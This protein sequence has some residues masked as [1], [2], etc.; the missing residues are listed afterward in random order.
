MPWAQSTTPVICMAPQGKLLP[1]VQ[2]WQAHHAEQGALEVQYLPFLP[3]HKYDDLLASCD[4]NFVRGE[5][6]F[7]RAQLAGRPLVWHIYP[8]AEDAHLTKLQAFL[9]LLLRSITHASRR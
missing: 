3:Q 9:E 8:Q 6:S 4:L 2:T 7:V 5:D 1:Q